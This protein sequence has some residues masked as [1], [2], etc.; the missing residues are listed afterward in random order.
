VEGTLVC[1]NNQGVPIAKHPVDFALT[2]QLLDGNS[3]FTTTT[4]PGTVGGQTLAAGELFTL[5]GWETKWNIQYYGPIYCGDGEGAN[6]MVGDTIQLGIIL[7]PSTDPACAPLAPADCS[8]GY[9][10]KHPSTWQTQ[11]VNF[12]SPLGSAMYVQWML[13]AELGASATQRE[14]AKAALDACFG[15]AASSPCTDD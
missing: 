1:A 6:T 3:S 10:K 8:P 12:Y 9:Y 5:V 15:T 14:Q 2:W 11:C 7:L 13:S 4:G